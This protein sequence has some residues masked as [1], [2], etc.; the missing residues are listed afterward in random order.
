MASPRGGEDHR[1]GLSSACSRQPSRCSGNLVARINP[2]SRGT[3]RSDRAVDRRSQRSAWQFALPTLPLRHQMLVEL[4]LMSSP[5]TP[6]TRPPADA[7]HEVAPSWLRLSLRDR[8][9]PPS[10]RVSPG[11]G[12]YLLG[13]RCRTHGDHRSTR[14]VGL[15]R[16]P[17]HDATTGV[18]ASRAGPAK[19]SASTSAGAIT[20]T[21]RCWSRDSGHG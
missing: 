17:S 8:E 20:A 4:R 14:Q 2:A 6:A 10:W 21:R 15:S 12:T 16:F 19:M 18:P 1:R 5:N 3:R 11:G 9:R 13:A 7:E